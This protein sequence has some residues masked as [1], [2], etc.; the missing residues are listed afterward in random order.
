MSPTSVRREHLD[1]LAVGLLITCCALWGLNQVAA[2][3]ALAEVPP[4]TQAALRS[5]AGALLVLGWAKARGVV[6]F[7]RDATLHG[8]LLTLRLVVA[9]AAVVLG[10]AL[11]NR[12]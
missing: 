2:K 8:G 6:L 5:L 3:A 1:A 10:L 9:L 7:D 4:L 11:V 12:R